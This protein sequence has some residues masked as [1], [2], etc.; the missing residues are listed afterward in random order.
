MAAKAS[1]GGAS[2][3]T[4]CTPAGKDR[5]HRVMWLRQNSPQ[6]LKGKALRVQQHGS[7]SSLP[8]LHPPLP[9][10]T[11]ALSWEGPETAL[12][13]GLPSSDHWGKILFFRGQAHVLCK[14]MWPPTDKKASK[15]V[16]GGNFIRRAEHLA[17]L[18][19]VLTPRRHF[20]GLPSRLHHKMEVCLPS[21]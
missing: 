20:S 15:A 9:S 6:E 3:R 12:T 1:S 11:S 7:S 4:T 14:W 13:L 21:T 2:G 16:L 19:S 10:L 8:S 18:C 5:G 17:T